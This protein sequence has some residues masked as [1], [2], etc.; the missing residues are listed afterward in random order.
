M[1]QKPTYQELE[2]ENKTLRQKLKVSE[3]N[4]IFKNFFDNNKAIMLQ[5]NS[6]TKQITDA[7]EAAVN[8]YGYSKNELLQKSINDLNN[9]TADEI[10]KLMKKAVKNK[11]NFFQFQQKLQMES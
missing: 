2:N 3:N 9:I 10:D 4:E 8:F 7:N 1:K 5:V 11:S 6:E